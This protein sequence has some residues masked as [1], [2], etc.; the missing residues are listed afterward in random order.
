MKNGNIQPNHIGDVI[1]QRLQSV[2]RRRRRPS[3]S[4]D[5]LLDKAFKLFVKLGYER[6]SIEAITAAAGVAK[7]TVYMRYQ[8]KETLFTAATQR[9]IEQWILPI[10]TLR[11]AEMNDLEETL[12]RIGRLLLDNVLSPAGL[13][14]LRLTGSVSR[15]LP[16]LGAHNVEQGT[17]P[18]LAYLADL[19]QRRIGS[20]LRGFAA[21]EGAAMAFMNLVVSGPANFVE[22]GVL[23]DRTSIERHL[24]S[25][26]C[27]F[28]HGVLLPSDKALPALEDENLRLKKILAETMIRLD[29]AQ[30]ALRQGRDMASVS[31]GAPEAAQPQPSSQPEKPARRPRNTAGDSSTTRR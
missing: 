1:P 4:N 14:L 20:R 31:L 8:D 11:N 23:M 9:A 30:Q 7:R 26:V 6:T 25:S 28:L 19:F 22:M 18:T 15:Q 27:L 13:R 5:Q 21:P 3:P 16:E 12:L 10:E 24:R 17:K 2:G 29:V